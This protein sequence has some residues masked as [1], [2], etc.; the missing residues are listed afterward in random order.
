MQHAILATAA[1]QS[2]QAVTADSATA[3]GIRLS[4]GCLK[5]G[6]GDTSIGW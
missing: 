2:W 3:A 5:R 1:A 6:A 4:L